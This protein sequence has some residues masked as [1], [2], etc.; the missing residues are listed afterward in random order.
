MI[1]ITDVKI[2]ILKIERPIAEIAEVPDR[3]KG[4]RFIHRM[5]DKRKSC[6]LPFIK[7]LTDVGVEGNSMGFWWVAGRGQAETI[8]STYKS[9]LLNEDPLNRERIWRKLWKANRLN[10]S[11]QTIL[12]PIDVAIWDLIGKYLGQPVYKLLG[13]YRSK[14]QAYGNSG[15]NITP[16]DYKEVLKRRKEQGFKAYKLTTQHEPKQAIQICEETREEAGD[17]MELMYD[18][19]ES[20]DY[21]EA[22]RVGKVLEELDYYWFEEPVQDYDLYN[23][24]RLREKLSIPICGTEVVEGSH[25]LTV[26]YLIRGAVD[27]VRSDVLLKGGI[28]GVMKTANLCDSFGVNCEIHASHNPA[29][30]F[31]NLHAVCAIHN[32]DFYEVWGGGDWRDFGVKNSLQI[33]RE[34]YIHVP[35][36]PGLGMELDWDRIENM[37]VG[38]M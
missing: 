10:N 27:I 2:Q 15:L 5:T 17:D 37:T 35:Q 32:C 3:R 22:L 23:L 28:S 18:A 30:E 11:P 13:G 29:L 33:D 14:V 7:V 12:G 31:A 38:E 21:Q 19:V 20:F 24:V 26:E 4:T 1:K 16:E 9:L 25:Y 6:Y 34:G 36:K 8:L